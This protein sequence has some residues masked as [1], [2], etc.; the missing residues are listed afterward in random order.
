MVMGEA[1]EMQPVISTGVLATACMK[2]E[3]R[4]NTG[5]PLLWSSVRPTGS[6]R[7][8]V[9]AVWG[10]GEVRSTDEVG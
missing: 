10:G 2:E 1:S 9:W 5:S 4:R 7:G 6:P 8:S 3:G